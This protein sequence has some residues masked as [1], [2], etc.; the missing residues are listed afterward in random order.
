MY[1]ENVHKHHTHH[2]SDSSKHISN[3]NFQ[4]IIETIIRQKS[5][6]RKNIYNNIRLHFTVFYLGSHVPTANL[7]NLK[8]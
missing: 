3:K 8:K 1:K 6:H 5:K 4:K 2:S 7:Q